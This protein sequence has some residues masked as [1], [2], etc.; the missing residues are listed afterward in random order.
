MENSTG[1]Q[2][3]SILESIKSATVIVDLNDLGWEKCQQLLSSMEGNNFTTEI[4]FIDLLRRRKDSKWTTPDD[5]TFF[6]N[7]F[8]YFGKTK[9]ERLCHI[10]KKKT[11][12]FICLSAESDKRINNL[13][14]INNSLIKIGRVEISNNPFDFI[15]GTPKGSQFTEADVMDSISKYLKTVTW[16]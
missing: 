9:N 12:I 8:G 7:D 10:M 15:V 14:Q 6:K 5:R 11:D 1:K 2:S 13:V 16:K 4:V 3:F